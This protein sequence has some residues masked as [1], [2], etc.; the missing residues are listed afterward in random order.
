MDLNELL[1]DY[2]EKYNVLATVDLDEWYQHPMYR[3]RWWLKKTLMS[4]HKDVYENN[5]RLIFYLGTNNTQNEKLFKT[6]VELVY[7]VDISNFFIVIA[8][9]NRRGKF[10]KIL[11]DNSKDLVSYTFEYFG[12]NT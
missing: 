12:S 6:F 11:A 2:A 8:T 5:E 7:E 10:E 9:N 1:Q 3:R 4:L